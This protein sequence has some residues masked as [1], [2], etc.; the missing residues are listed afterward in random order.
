MHLDAGGLG[1]GHDLINNLIDSLLLDLLA[2]LG[3]V[4]GAHPGPEETEI[5]VNLRHRAH[6]GAG[7]LAGGLLVDGDGGRKSVD[8]VHIGLLHLAQKHPG[9]RTEGLHIPPLSLGVDG[10][11]GQRGLAGAGK[12]GEHHQFVPGD[13]HINVFQV[14]FPGS[15][16]KKWS[17]ID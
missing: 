13:V 16:D 7:I 14:V 17:S 15:F 4:G 2:A 11:K 9:V 6:G 5:V 3:A 10:V 1:K 12:S 8:I